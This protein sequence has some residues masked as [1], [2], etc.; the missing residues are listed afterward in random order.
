MQTD[1][2]NVT[3]I[4]NMACSYGIENVILCPG[5]RNIPLIK[6]FAERGTFKCRRITDERSAGFFAIGLSLSEKLSPAVVCCTSGSALLNLYPAMAEAVFQKI[7]I[8]VISADRPASAIKQME[9]QTIIQENVFAQ[10]GV[11]S[12]CLPEVKDEDDLIFCNRLVNEAFMWLCDGYPVHVNVPISEPLFTEE[13]T[14]V[15][16][17]RINLTRIKRSIEGTDSETLGVLDKSEKILVVVGQHNPD[18]RAH[19]ISFPEGWAVIGENLSNGIVKG[20]IYG[21][22][23]ILSNAKNNGTLC[24]DLVITCEGHIISKNIRKFI[25]SCGAEHWHISED[26][27]ITDLSKNVSRI[28]RCSTEDFAKAVK[29]SG[30]KKAP[31]YGQSWKNAKEKTDKKINLAKIGFSSVLAT[32]FLLEK[33][34]PGSSVHI[35]NSMAVRIAQ[36]YGASPSIKYFCNRGTN[37]IDGSVSSAAGYAANDENMNFLIIGDLSFMY[38]INGLW[39]DYLKPNFRILLLNNGGGAIFDTLK[40]L[41]MNDKNRKFITGAHNFSA[42]MQAETYGLEY[43]TASDEKSLSCGIEELVGAD[44]KKPVLLEIRTDRITDI[45]E[46]EKYFEE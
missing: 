15:T 5:S 16:S 13:E 23:I 7:P 24:P 20:M 40:G 19:Y 3:E 11:K 22:D 42:R 8:M 38:D 43:L 39:H 29:I 31:G 36:F 12:F 6:S 35:G 46:F 32:K 34:P 2:R 10:M 41:E 27:N 4:V 25:K 45:E 17:R 26:E 9:G 21:A 28:I 37:G 44:K 18:K 14:C 33:V 1:K 30:L